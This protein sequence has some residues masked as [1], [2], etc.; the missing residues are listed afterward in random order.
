MRG[1]GR[2]LAL[3]ALFLGIVG[4]VGVF[5]MGGTQVPTGQAETLK[6]VTHSG[7]TPNNPPANNNLAVYQEYER[8]TNV[9]VEYE[10]VQ[11]ANY[12]E[13]MRARLAAGTNLPDVMNM[14]F[15]ADIGQYGRDG[16][17]IPQETLMAK[18][19]PNMT[20]WFAQPEN[21]TYKLMFTSP[22]GHIYGVGGYS[23]PDVLSI[24]YQWN[25]PWLDKLG[26][27]IPKNQTEMVA[28][29]KAYRDKDPNG[30]GKQDEIPLVPD[31]AYTTRLMANMY[32]FD[33][34]IATEFGVDKA[35]K[36]YWDMTHPRFKDYLAFMNMLYTERLL[37]QAYATDGEERVM[38]MVA[39]D[40]AGCIIMWG[41]YASWW[42]GMSKYAPAP[43]DESVPIFVNSEPIEGPNGDKFYTRR[44]I[45]GTDPLAITKACKKPEVAMRWIDFVTYS[46][47][48]R[49][50]QNF[51][52]EG[53][54]Y[55]KENGQIVRI[56]M[57][58]LSP[59]DTLAKLGGYQ[60]PWATVQWED[61]FNLR[62][63]KWSIDNNTAYRK[64][65]KPPTFPMVSPLPDETTT[66]NKYM[67]DI[68]TYRDEMIAKFI[69]GT[70]SLSNWDT[71]V[72]QLKKLGIDEVVKVRQQQYDRFVKL[73]GTK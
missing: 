66:L 12:T 58:G 69:N 2:T 10:I 72:A 5:A 51:G 4:L 67:T 6:V 65:Y 61:A 30:N 73:G 19:A 44:D 29:L 23:L 47:E 32:G 7:Y 28:A 11:N 64:Y 21:K 16:V 71:Y 34:A 33:W 43:G 18:Y 42:G 13:V 14:G 20:K 70:E 57:D 38:E 53:K 27:K 49:M 35:G 1:I 37:N 50:L 62:F 9:H 24:C 8:L 26:L 59:V 68:G 31:G 15:A 36:V 40:T 17:I 60:P 45:L 55:K 54:S 63:A 41:T 56:G 22:D 46:L 52:I 48:A 39:K 25:K 3:V